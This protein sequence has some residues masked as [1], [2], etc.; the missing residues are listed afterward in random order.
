MCNQLLPHHGCVTVTIQLQQGIYIWAP[1]QALQQQN[2]IAEHVTSANNRKTEHMAGTCSVMMLLGS[3][4]TSLCPIVGMPLPTT[5]FPKHAASYRVVMPSAI[6][7]C[8]KDEAA[9]VRPCRA[10]IL[11]AALKAAMTCSSPCSCAATSRGH[12]SKCTVCANR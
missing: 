7:H 5:L 8:L 2:R 1:P 6:G 9:I 4:T 11:N 3:S 12:S 10:H